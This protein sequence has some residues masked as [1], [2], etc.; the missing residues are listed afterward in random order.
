[1]KKDDLVILPLR[2]SFEL[3]VGRVVGPYRYRTDL[4]DSVRH[5]RPVEWLW[6]D[7]DRRTFEQDII[8]S[9]GAAMT[10]CQIRR[11]DA[12]QRIRSKLGLQ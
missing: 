12:E 5:T 4:G 9:I 10:V 8:N 6:K 2:N 7:L 11:N 1:M 3:A